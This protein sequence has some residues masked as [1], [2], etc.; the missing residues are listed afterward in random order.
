MGGILRFFFSSGVIDPSG[1]E[2]TSAAIMAIQEI[3]NNPNILP[4]TELLFS[5]E[6]PRPLYLYAVQAAEKLAEDHFNK[7][8]VDVVIGPTFTATTKASAQIFAQFGIIQVGW[9]SDSELSYKENYPYYIRTSPA[10]SFQASVLADVIFYKFSWDKVAIFPS[11]DYFGSSSY[12]E[13]SSKCD[14]LGITILNSYIFSKG[15]KNIRP[16][17]TKALTSLASKIVIFADAYDTAKLILDGN[18]IGPLINKSNK[19]VDL[20]GKYL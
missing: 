14:E 16:I 1:L 20:P 13:F 19:S 9:N 10:D 18:D 17:T 15:V 4:H 11:D 12:L 7:T 2:F 5:I 8:G 3:N 6:V